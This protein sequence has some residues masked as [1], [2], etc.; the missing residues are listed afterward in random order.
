RWIDVGRAGVAVVRALWSVVRA[1]APRPRLL[2]VCRLPLRV[3][4]A[5]LMA[6]LRPLPW[7]RL[8]IGAGIALGSLLLFLFAVLT[9]AELT[10]DLKPTRSAMATRESAP[11]LL[12][13]EPPP[14]ALPAKADVVPKSTE[15]G[16]AF[17]IDD[18]APRVVAVRKPAPAA[19]P[20]AGKKAQAKKKDVEVFI[21]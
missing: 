6:A 1:P 4:H 19:R 3:F 16:T 17:E 21:P 11:Q 13:D 7:R 2:D 12:L 18:E 8:A 15:L 14:P 10:D 9:A 20:A 5:E